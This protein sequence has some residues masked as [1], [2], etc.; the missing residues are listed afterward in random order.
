MS[1]KKFL[2]TAE[3]THF[4]GIEE[5]TVRS[6]VETGDLKA[7]ADRG[8]WKY[9]REDIEALIKAGRLHPTREMPTVDDMDFDESMGFGAA[10]ATDDR[11]DFL[12]LDEDALAGESTMISGSAPVE[13]DALRMSFT[14]E[15]EG[16]ASDVRVF[17][18]SD[19]PS[20]DS[21]IHLRGGKSSSE[22]SVMPGAPSSSD[23]QALA[24]DA[25]SASSQ[26]L[27]SL[28]GVDLDRLGRASLTGQEI[29]VEGIVLDLDDESSGKLQ[30]P[31]VGGTQR[32][33][34]P[35][36]D[37][38]AEFAD[39]FADE[40]TMIPSGGTSRLEI[41]TG[42]TSR[43]E[44]PADL[45]SRLELPHE[46]PPEADSVLADEG[47]A[48]SEG[49]SGLTFENTDSGLTL[50]TGDSGLTMD[51][52]DS[53]LTLDA[54]D[55]GLTLD[56]G[57]S[58][59]T[60]DAG[61]SG[62]SLDGGDSGLS[63]EVVSDDMAPAAPVAAT[64]RMQQI[65][66]IDEDLDFNSGSGDSGGT[67]RLAVEEKFAEE[68]AFIDD[69]EDGQQTSVIMVDD[70]DEGDGDF[71][72]TLS[73]AVDAG[74]L[75]EDLEVS[76]DLE[77]GY[78]ADEQFGTAEADVID[79]EDEAFSDDAMGEAVSEEDAD[80]Y[81][82]PVA[83]M[84]PRQPAWGAVTAVM[85]MGAAGL[86]GTNLWIMWEGIAT[87]WTGGETSGPAAMLISTIGSMLG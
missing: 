49:D 55:S 69:D 83:R 87:M 22:T 42:G 38:P 64:Q 36:L 12:E 76:E 33:A 75:V 43:M 61:D 41:P 30:Q 78:G 19:S 2:T 28:E 84:E 79:A 70:D 27:Q 21:D 46:L 62:L 39:E 29:P 17:T 71:V 9:R 14:E 57:D 7:L 8:T 10:G 74:E 34:R 65:G 6:L 53:G 63:L 54:A 59:L 68:R 13:A 82:A 67:R 48:T 52:G 60:L 16:S 31:S 5:E 4:F 80:T 23:V 11:V 35:E 58:G 44:P 1:Q 32:L 20:S 66:E 47:L 81:A 15:P 86:I 56:A 37:L 25:A 72:G 77:G 73:G 40:P 51:A 45:P 26:Y 18:P 85:V 50:D 24:D 3:V